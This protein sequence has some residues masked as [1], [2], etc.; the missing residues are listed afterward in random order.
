M[1][2]GSCAEGKAAIEAIETAIMQYRI[3][4][5]AENVFSICI[6]QSIETLPRERDMGC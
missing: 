4:G 1:L 5:T 3:E 2:Q 6:F